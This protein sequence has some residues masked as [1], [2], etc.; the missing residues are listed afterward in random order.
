M[1]YSPED[2][3]AP[4]VPE[5]PTEE[6]NEYNPD[7]GLRQDFYDQMG[8]EQ[9]LTVYATQEEYEQLG[10]EFHPENALEPSNQE[11]S[12]DSEDYEVVTDGGR[13]SGRPE[14]SFDY[15]NNSKIPWKNPGEPSK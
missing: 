7:H 12:Q 13:M 10:T 11:N 1:R 15:G 14:A 5:A 8:V 9:Q 2:S 6:G 3:G 4:I